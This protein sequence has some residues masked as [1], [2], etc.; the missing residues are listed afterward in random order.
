MR[1]KNPGL[2]CAA[3]AEKENLYYSVAAGAPSEGPAGPR[4]CEKEEDLCPAGFS[5]WPWLPLLSSLPFS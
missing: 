2:G 3:E 4:T 1:A 5:S